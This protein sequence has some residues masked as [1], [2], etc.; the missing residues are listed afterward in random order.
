M[1]QTRLKGAMC[2]NARREKMYL[3]QEYCKLMV[4]NQVLTHITMDFVEKLPISG[5][6]DTILVIV[7][8]FIK[9]N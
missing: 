7:V 9:S 2:A 3:I 5:G 1:W 6:K 8:W 4:P